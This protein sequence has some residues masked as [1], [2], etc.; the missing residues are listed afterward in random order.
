VRKVGELSYI[1]GDHLGSTSVVADADGTK[2]S[3]IRYKACPAGMLTLWDDAARVKSTLRAESP[4]RKIRSIGTGTIMSDIIHSNTPT[5][6]DVI[7][8]FILSRVE[9]A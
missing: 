8:E 5:P 3:E 2:V 4:Q 9:G 7:S 1:L 6:A